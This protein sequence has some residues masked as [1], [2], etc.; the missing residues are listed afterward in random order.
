MKIKNIILDLG[1]VIIRVD[2]NLSWEYL[3]Q[4]GVTKKELDEL[5]NFCV[6]NNIYNAIETNDISEDDFRRISRLF[7]TTK[8]PDKQL[9]DSWNIMNGEMPAK[10]LQLLKQLS[11][12]YRL[13][14]LSNTN[15]IHFADIDNRFCE[16]YGYN[17]MRDLFEETYLSHEIGMR[18]PDPELYKYVLKHSDLIPEQT[19]FVDD[20]IENID[21]AEMVGIIGCHLTDFDLIK[22]MQPYLEDKF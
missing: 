2:P 14:L 3:L 4:K 9:N 17:S 18:K 21:A 10:N 5:Y 7:I 6:E 19:L 16:L 8:I 11:T 1:E 15:S 13:F 20:R 22:A 12:H